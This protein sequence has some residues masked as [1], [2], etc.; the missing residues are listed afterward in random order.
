V[1]IQ[2]IL[3]LHLHLYGA[4][5]YDRE[6]FRESY[7]AHLTDVQEYF[8]DRPGDLLVLDICAGEGWKKLCPFLGK[9][10]PSAVFPHLNV[11]KRKVLK[12]TTR[13]WFWQAVGTLGRESSAWHE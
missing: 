6:R 8:R 7:V 3:K 10:V 5:Q 1:H 12:R 11:G 13:R 9:P 4:L 2:T